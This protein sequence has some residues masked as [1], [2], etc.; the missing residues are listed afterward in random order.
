MVCLESL[1]RQGDLAHSYEIVVV[2]NGSTDGTRGV[3]ESLSTPGGA[4]RYVSEPIPGLL[5]GRH[6]GTL[7]TSAEILVFVDDD[8]VATEGWLG[9]I[10]DA[11]TDSETQIVGGASTP[12]FQTDPPPWI[13][14]Y[15][16]HDAHGSRCE[17][18]SLLDM[19]DARRPIDANFVWGLN[20]AIRRRA[21]MD[22]GGFHP[23]NIPRRLQHFQGDGE[24]GLTIAANAMGYKAVYEPVAK[25]EHQISSER[26]TPEYFEARA[27]YQG[28]CNSY[29]AV[30]ARSKPVST[31]DN[32]WLTSTRRVLSMF[33]STLRPAGERGLADRLRLAQEAG[34]RFHQDALV[35]YPG[36]IEW[37]DRADYWDYRLPDLGSG[38]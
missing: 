8:I 3:V 15:W 1:L 21:L 33:K 32:R 35:S 19:G 31:A 9:A 36:L 16:I 25:V 4:L 22:L 20:F 28:V 12:R 30:R 37:V 27:F 14:D 38:E 17:W 6:R 11:F 26:L 18:L 10:L 23:D 13:S 2:D 24:T 5:S 29:S 34:Y 7:E